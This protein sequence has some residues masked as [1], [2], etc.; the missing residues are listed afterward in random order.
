MSQQ[1]NLYDPA[2]ERQRDLLTAANFALAGG[3][4][5]LVLAAWG[6][7][8]QVVAAGLEGKRT[9]IDATLKSLREQAG[10]LEAQVQSLKPNQQLADELARTR[11]ELGSRQAV[12]AV[13][14]K[15]LGPEATSFS[16]YLRGLAR[17]GGGDPWLT[18]FSVD[19]DAN[20]ME[21][22]GRTL[23]PAT[24]PDYIR[25]LN[26]EKL[27]RGQTFSALQLKTAAEAAP[28]GAA[29]EAGKP[30]AAPAGP[31]YSDFVLVPTKPAEKQP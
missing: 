2:L 10:A 14:R 5:L 6:T 30:P 21:I 15:G 18:G 4:L 7:W 26:N 19:A 31:T 20:T 13:L 8:G 1:I 29:A 16:E 3:A 9:A 24:L 27:F 23:D 17:Q 12:L 22:R 11:Q 28:G 25:R